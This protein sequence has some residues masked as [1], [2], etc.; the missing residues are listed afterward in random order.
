MASPPASRAPTTPA[1]ANSAYSVGPD[2]S[3]SNVGDAADDFDAI[4]SV[5]TKN[6]T[7]PQLL[8]HLKSKL[9]LLGV[10]R[11]EKL[12]RTENGV[13]KHLKNGRLADGDLRLLRNYLKQ[14][15]IGVI[16]AWAVCHTRVSNRLSPSFKMCR[17]DTH[18]P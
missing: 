2:D 5:K 9:T 4:E 1:A 13:R 10:L 14:A 18:T 16:Q 17:T 8:V 11:A 6:M 3:A 12:G 15:P 7:S